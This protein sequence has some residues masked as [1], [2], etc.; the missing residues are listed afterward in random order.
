MNSNALPSVDP[1]TVCATARSVIYCGLLSL[2]PATCYHYD[3]HPSALPARQLRASWTCVRPAP[4]SDCGSKGYLRRP[5]LRCGCLPN[6]S[7]DFAAQQACAWQSGTGWKTFTASGEPRDTGPVC[8]RIGRHL[9]SNCLFL[10]PTTN[11]SIPDTD[12]DNH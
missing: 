10:F 11:P 4:P 8:A 2:G 3:R 5:Y 6:L 7:A 9:A 12:L 1:S